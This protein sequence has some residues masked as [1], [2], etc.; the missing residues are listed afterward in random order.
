MADVMYK[1]SSSAYFHT[2]QACKEPSKDF[3]RVKPLEGRVFPRLSI[4]FF[5]VAEQSLPHNLLSFILLRFKPLV[6]FTPARFQRGLHARK[7]PVVRRVPVIIVVE[8]ASF[9]S[10]GH[11]EFFIVLTCLAG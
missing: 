4:T 8:R 3:L 11:L 2:A 9:P 10:Y 7:K 1:K 5:K 6:T